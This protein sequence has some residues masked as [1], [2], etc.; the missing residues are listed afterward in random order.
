MVMPA[1]NGI[2]INSYLTL[3][4]GDIS[5]SYRVTGFDFLSTPGVMY[6]SMDPTMERDLTPVRERA[7]EDD[8]SDFF[9]LGGRANG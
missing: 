9:W 6:V 7:P 2:K 4:V 1:N 5:R 8:P 3:T